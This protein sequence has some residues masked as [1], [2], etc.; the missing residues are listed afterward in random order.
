MSLFFEITKFNR[1]ENTVLDAETQ[2]IYVIK[3]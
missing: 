3:I 2:I 1:T